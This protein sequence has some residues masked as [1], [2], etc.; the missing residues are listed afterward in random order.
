MTFQHLCGYSL[1]KTGAGQRQMAFTSGG[2]HLT[3]SVIASKARSGARQ[4]KARQGK[5]K[6]MRHLYFKDTCF[7]ISNF[8]LLICNCVPFLQVGATFVKKRQ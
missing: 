4:G 3:L 5:I 8:K 6:F 1:D 7:H 2:L